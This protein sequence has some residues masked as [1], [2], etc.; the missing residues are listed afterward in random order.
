MATTGL[1][2]AK[3]NYIV[4]P[5]KFNLWLAIISLI[6]VFG[7]LTSAYLVA[8]SMVKQPEFFD[9]PNLLWIN[10]GIILLSSF[11]MQ[12]AVWRVRKGDEKQALIGL[13]LTCLM[14]IV[15]L[16][17]QYSVYQEMVLGGNYFV[18]PMRADDSVSY[19]YILTGLHGTHIIAGLIALFFALIKTGFKMYKPGKKI[20]SIEMTATFWHFLDLLWVYLFVFLLFTQQG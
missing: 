9:I 7:G 19:F 2:M 18:D 16:F 4:H 15:F 10:T 13:L 14:G 5:H 11:S 12:F 17:G 3:R 1:N 8:R 6:M 20:L